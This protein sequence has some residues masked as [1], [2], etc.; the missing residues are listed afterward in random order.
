LRDTGN[1]A[2]TNAQATPSKIRYFACSRTDD[3]TS[4]I[5]VAASHVAVAD[6]R[7]T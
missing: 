5:L 6:R 2:P 3:G 7:V 1:C 4:S